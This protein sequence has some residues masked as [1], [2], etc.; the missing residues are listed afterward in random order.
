MS[1]LAYREGAVLW[2]GPGDRVLHTDWLEHEG[3]WVPAEQHPGVRWPAPA[4]PAPTPGPSFGEAA[5]AIGLGALGVWALSRLLSDPEPRRITA[6]AERY[7]RKGAAVFADTKGWP[8]PPLLNGRIPDVYA[9]FPDGR[10]HAV[11]VENDR[12]IE[13]SHA[14]AQVRDLCTWATR[15][16]SRRFSVEVVAGGRGGRG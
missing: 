6:I 5:V 4:V 10:E 11:E 2:L 8:R 16:R 14:R 1:V 7:E 9:V 12:S 13:R 15:S 3:R